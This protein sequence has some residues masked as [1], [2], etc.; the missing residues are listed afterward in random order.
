MKKKILRPKINAKLLLTLAKTEK[1]T[2]KRVLLAYSNDNE[3]AKMSR[4]FA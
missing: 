3:F 1:K 2:K 4:S